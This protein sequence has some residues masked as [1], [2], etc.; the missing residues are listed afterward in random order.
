[1]TLLP[2][3]GRAIETRIIEI[4]FWFSHIMRAVLNASDGVGE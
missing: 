4:R 1:M 3:P 2:V